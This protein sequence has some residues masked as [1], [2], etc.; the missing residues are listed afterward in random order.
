MMLG[1]CE[2]GDIVALESGEL[3][4]LGSILG[5]AKGKRVS[6]FTPRTFALVTTVE[7]DTLREVHGTWRSMALSAPV[8]A[9]VARGE[10]LREMRGINA[11][12]QDGSANVDPLASGE[13]EREGMF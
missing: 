8:V 11:R 5:L 13:H 3:I 9:V 6:A 12:K 4:E 10:W 2:P 1:D 7:R